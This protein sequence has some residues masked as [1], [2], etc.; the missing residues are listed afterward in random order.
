MGVNL[1]YP[2]IYLEELPSSIHVITGVSTAATAFVD[3]FRRGPMEAIETPTPGEPTVYRPR[4][5]RVEGWAEFQRLYGGLD[6]E[7]EASYGVMQFFLNGGQTAWV[8][9]VAG[10]HAVAATCQVALAV[11]PLPP[12]LGD[13]PVVVAGTKLTLSWKV[14]PQDPANAA[15]PGPVASFQVQLS[16]DGGASFQPVSPILP[17]TRSSFTVQPSAVAQQAIYRVV[18]RDASGAR[19]AADQL[20]VAVASAAGPPQKATPD[21]LLGSPPL[22]VPAALLPFSAIDPGAWGNDLRV[23]VMPVAAGRVARPRQAASFDRLAAGFD[24]LVEEVLGGEV[25]RS[26]SFRNLSW[27]PSSPSFA[28][29]VVAA[30][31]ELVRCAVPP[32]CDDPARRP[33]PLPKAYT[34]YLSGGADGEAPTLDDIAAVLVDGGPLDRIAPNV[35][36]LLCL[37]A[38]A[39]AETAD[40]MESVLTAALAYCAPRRAFLLVDPPASASTVEAVESWA[41]PYLL[42]ENDCG[43]VYFPRLFIPDPLHGYRPRNVGPS[44]TLAGVYARTDASQGVWKAP[45]GIDAVLQGADVA[46][47]LTDADDGQLN[48]LGINALRTF[49]VFGDVSWGARTLAGADLLESEWKYV[50]VRRLVDYIESSLVQGLKWAVFEPNGPALWA[51]LRFAA[52]QFLAGL[53]SEGAFAGAAAADSYFVRCDET[54]TTPADLAQGIAVL[55]VGV[56]PVEP[57]EFVIIQIQQVAGESQ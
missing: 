6:D 16:L 22:A 3:R 34:G 1:S 20:T 29:A 28:P 42:L 9:R 5:A 40:E 35:F 50:P 48:V 53:W 17:A 39:N 7:S 43:A 36:N 56:A 11:Q 49:P 30:G 25:L 41:K 45:A 4:A 47:A 51:S 8:V 10:A 15:D 44:G 18:A 14:G 27:D 57:A 54:T 26:E 31:S 12:L 38:A 21:V 13:P 23:T 37:P 55:W 32:S 2:G 46:L 24:L 19:L 52:G 33:P